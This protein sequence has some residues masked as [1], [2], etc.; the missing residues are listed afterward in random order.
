MLTVNAAS[1]F[2]S[3]GGAGGLATVTYIG[4]H[5]APTGTTFTVSGA[6]IGDAADDRIVVLCINGITNDS[7]TVSSAT[8][9]GVGTA[10]QVGISGA[11]CENNAFIHSLLVTSGTTADIVVTFSGAVGKFGLAVYNVN[12][13]TNAT[14]SDTAANNAAS[15]GAT[16]DL[17][18]TIP[19][20][21][22]SIISYGDADISPALVSYSSFDEDHDTVFGTYYHHSSASRATES[23]L[24]EHTET[25]TPATAPDGIGTCAAA[26]G[27]A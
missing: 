17:T 21:G 24:T 19:A 13:T 1:G 27:P 2:G 9:G 20:N 26:W 12:G 18:L 4:E 22:V 14:A 7:R 10:E 25:I 8:I 23:L 15:P 5:N 11:G 6:S 3:G 16:I